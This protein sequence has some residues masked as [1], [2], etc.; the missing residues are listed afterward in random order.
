MVQILKHNYGKGTV[1]RKA[2]RAVV[3]SVTTGKSAVKEGA[4][5]KRPDTKRAKL[6]R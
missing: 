5:A 6:P 3:K 1:S 4:G 2:I